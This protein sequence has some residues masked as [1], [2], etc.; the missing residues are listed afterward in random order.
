MDSYTNKEKI[1]TELIDKHKHEI[2]RYAKGYVYD[3]FTADDLAQEAFMELYKNFEH[4]NP[5]KVVGYMKTTIERK[6]INF[7]RDNKYLNDVSLDKFYESPGTTP[8]AEELY[9]L[10]MEE[11]RNKALSKNILEKLRKKNQEWYDVVVWNYYTKRTLVE[12]A[13]IKGVEPKTIYAR[14]N[15]AEKWLKK[16]FGELKEE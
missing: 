15:R 7:I 14:L 16:T 1:F 2:F 3:D 4:V 8:S 5:A 10:K 9:I 13:R 6:F 11:K 12:L